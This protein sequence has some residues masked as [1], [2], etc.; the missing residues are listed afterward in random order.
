MS[1]AL[2]RNTAKVSIL[3]FA[4]KLAGALKTI[5]IARY[6]GSAGILDAY[7]LAFLPISFLA[8]S[9]SGSMMNALLPAY[10]EQTEQR[11]RSAALTLYY[12]VQRRMF[13]GL[14][15]VAVVL[16][17][18][19]GP[20]LRLLATGFDQ[21]KIRATT[22]LMFLM[23]PILPLSALNICWRAS[24]NAEEHFAI[25]A[26]SPAMVPIF[27]VLALVT[28][29]QAYGITSL[30]IGTVGGALIES[31]LLLYCVRGMG[32][33]VIGRPGNSSAGLAG[34]FEQYLPAAGGSLVMNSSALVEQSMAAMLGPGSV[35]ILNYGTRLVTVLIAI[36]PTAVSTVVLPWF[37]R[38]TARGDAAG[39]RRKILRYGLLG[40]GITVP[41]TIALIVG[42]HLL[43]RLLFERG[44]FTTA[45]TASVAQVQDFALLRVPFSVLL[46]LLIPLVASLRRNVL[47]LMVALFGIAAN[48][49][50][51][52]LLMK[53]LG[54]AGLALS[55][56]L[57]NLLMV[58]VL[59]GQLLRAPVVSGAR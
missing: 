28:L 26:I 3:T 10:V 44:A 21:E 45:D 20:V 52:M 38:F 53:P 30:A 22:N 36:G 29:T 1:P 8:D 35:A 11:G 57:V 15:A 49:I 54:V 5:V 39:L 34:V 4:S 24:L 19:A 32:T 42:S 13:L 18:F 40:L 47:L 25:A 27:T 59:S 6:F 43:V 23:L 7:L 2:I 56:T 41:A 16:A 48:V 46:A 14:V 9:I 55:T 12:G 31:L 50:L 37:S 33:P 17:V 51:S 58:V